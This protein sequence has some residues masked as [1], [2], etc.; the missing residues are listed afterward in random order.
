M[1]LLNIYRTVVGKGDTLVPLATRE[2]FLIPSSFDIKEVA[3]ALFLIRNQTRGDW[4]R[5]QRLVSE[6]KEF[7]LKNE[8]LPFEMKYIT[9]KNYLGQEFIFLFSKTINHDCFYQVVNE[10]VGDEMGLDTYM[11]VVSAGFTDLKTCYGRSE[12]LNKDSRSVDTDLLLHFLQ[13]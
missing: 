6:S 1:S 8:T 4:F 12:T 11:I 9:T 7:V 10:L 5:M 13:G 2:V 3:D